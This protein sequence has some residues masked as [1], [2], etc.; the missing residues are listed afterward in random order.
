MTAA[1]ARTRA[2]GERQDNRVHTALLLV[3][4]SLQITRALHRATADCF[5]SSSIVC[6][7]SHSG[8]H[9]LN[10]TSQPSAQLGRT[11]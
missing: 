10:V 9:A 3:Y 7:A 5:G 8:P 1:V 2:N 11:P 4:K 6:D